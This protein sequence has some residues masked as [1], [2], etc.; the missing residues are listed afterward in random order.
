LAQQLL[1][2][3]LFLAGI[4]GVAGFPVAVAAIAALSPYLPADL[5]RASGISVDTRMLAF[6]AAISLATG[7]LFGFGPLF[8]TK[9]VSA[10]KSLNKPIASRAERTPVCGTGW[11]WPRSRLRSCF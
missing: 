5:S 2:E 7:V 6:T 4:G 11:R 9:G 10:G 8:G 3:S 1:T